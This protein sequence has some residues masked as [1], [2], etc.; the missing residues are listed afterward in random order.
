MDKAATEL[1]TLSPRKYWFEIN[2]IRRKLT[3]SNE[4]KQKLI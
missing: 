3:K 2:D 4:L 1:F